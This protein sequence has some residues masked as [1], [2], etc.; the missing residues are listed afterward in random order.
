MCHESS[1]LDGATHIRGPRFHRPE[2]PDD[3]AE[4]PDALEESQASS[5]GGDDVLWGKN[6]AMKNM[7]FLSTCFQYVFIPHLEF[8]LSVSYRN[9]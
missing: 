1:I 3:R 7:A 4:V 8:V 2:P 6:G 9:L 5:V